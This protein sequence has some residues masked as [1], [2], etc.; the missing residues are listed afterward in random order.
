MPP[1]ERIRSCKALLDSFPGWRPPLL[2]LDS[3]GS[4]LIKAYAKEKVTTPA[5][6]NITRETDVEK[7]RARLCF[8]LIN[9]KCS[10]I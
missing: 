9:G 7:L 10:D 5:K 1:G 2:L 6:R 4:N 8:A 3:E